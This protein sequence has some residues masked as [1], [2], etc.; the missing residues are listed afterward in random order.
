M[1]EAAFAIHLPSS[2]VSSI[3]IALRPGEGSLAFHHI[4]FEFA[5][6]G[7]SILVDSE[8]F[9]LLH[10]SVPMALVLS[11]DTVWVS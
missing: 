7:T 10:A 2:K 3:F 4:F 1:P 6:E 5:S 8:A 11:Q 9:A